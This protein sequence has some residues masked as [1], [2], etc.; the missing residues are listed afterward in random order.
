MKRMVL[1]SLAKLPH[2]LHQLVD[3]LRGQ[4]GGGLVKDQNLIVPVE[5]LQDLH[6]LLHTHG[7]ILHLGVQIHRESLYFSDSA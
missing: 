4:H 5:H 6:S 7:D 1:P 3:L 2:D